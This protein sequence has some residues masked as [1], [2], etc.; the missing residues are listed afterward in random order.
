MFDD[1]VARGWITERYTG[2]YVVTGSPTAWFQRLKAATLAAGEHAVASHRA[3][4]RLHG[5]DGFTNID[6]VEVSVT[7][8]HL[9]R[10]RDGTVAHHVTAL[11]RPTSSRSRGSPAPVWPGPWSTSGRSVRTRSSCPGR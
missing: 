2:V 8:D 6:M 10:H 4:A 7:R 1:A 5:L 11:A 9:W 3:A